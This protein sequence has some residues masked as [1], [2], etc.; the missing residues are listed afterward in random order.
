[1]QTEGRQKEKNSERLHRI[2]RDTSFESAA[3]KGKQAYTESHY[4]S[5]RQDASSQEDF[6]A[7]RNFQ[8][9][10]RLQHL[11][12]AE[13]AAWRRKNAQLKNS[14]ENISKRAEKEGGEKE[15]EREE[16]GSIC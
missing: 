2:Q 13:K 7:L 1:M 14:K 3:S 8:S 4:S 15:V 10:K 9:G 5:E 6:K 16:E 11:T 12:G